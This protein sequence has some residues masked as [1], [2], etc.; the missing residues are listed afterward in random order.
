ME[1]FLHNKQHIKNLVIV[2]IKE[3][4]KIYAAVYIENYIQ[5]HFEIAKISES[6]SCIILLHSKVNAFV[7]TPNGINEGLAGGCGS[8]NCFAKKLSSALLITSNHHKQH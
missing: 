2:V 1:T 4:S 8:T 5:Y 6:V 7:K 3:V